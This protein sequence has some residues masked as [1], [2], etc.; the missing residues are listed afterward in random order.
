[1]RQEFSEALRWY[2]KAADQDH[3]AA[4]FDIGVMYAYG[5]GVPQDFVE[6]YA[7][8]NLAAK[9]FA[10]VAKYRDEFESEMTTHQVAEGQHRTKEL[11]MA[12]DAKLNEAK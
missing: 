4:Q 10:P 6:A 7:W 12:L 2:H 1:M 5:E 11:R 8:F 9:T 3:A